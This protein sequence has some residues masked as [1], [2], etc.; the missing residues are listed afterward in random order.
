[1]HV[2]N[3][4]ELLLRDSPVLTMFR[5]QDR[6]SCVLETTTPEQLAA[7]QKNYQLWV[8]VAFNRHRDLE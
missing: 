2:F 6:H 5:R 7:D 3:C 1:M 4:T 8:L